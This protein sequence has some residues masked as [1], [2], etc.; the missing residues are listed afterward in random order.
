MRELESRVQELEKA[1][2]EMKARVSI[3]AV[4]TGSVAIQDSSGRTRLLLGV[5]E[6]DAPGI[7]VLGPDGNTRVMIALGSDGEPGIIMSG[8]GGT[9]RLSLSLLG[10]GSITL[11]LQDPEGR[12][13]RSS[14]FNR[15]ALQRSDSWMQTA[16]C[17]RS[18]PDATI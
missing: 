4:E 3:G 15:T 7:H 14:A 1:L 18:S 8:E 10:D 11:N 16:T 2:A 5:S 9:T 17:L 6:G 12:P 13:R